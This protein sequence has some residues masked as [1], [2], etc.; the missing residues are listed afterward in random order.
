MT[1]I[2]KSDKAMI[3]VPIEDNKVNGQVKLSLIDKNHRPRE[4]IPIDT[5]QVKAECTNC[6]D[7]VPLDQAHLDLDKSE[8][9]EEKIWSHVETIKESFHKKELENG[10]PVQWTSQDIAILCSDNCTV[11]HKL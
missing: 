3:K 10:A 9:W 2:Q 6:G 5:G 1:Q 8:I 4:D 11:A 7:K